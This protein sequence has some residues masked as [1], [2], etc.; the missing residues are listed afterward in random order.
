[1][2]KIAKIKKVNNKW[3]VL[4]RKDK[5]LGEYDTKEEAV[6]RLQQVEY[7]KNKS[8]E[9]LKNLMKQAKVLDKNLFN[10][11]C[12]AEAALVGADPTTELSYSYIMRILRKDHKDKV[13][14]FVKSYKEAFDEGFVSELENFEEAALLQAIKAIDLKKEDLTGDE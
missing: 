1:M 4:S 14:L 5:S 7:F 11:L 12:L 13:E 6:K 2:I 10:I 9:I 8:S 3:K